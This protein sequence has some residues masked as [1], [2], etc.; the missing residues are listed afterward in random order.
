MYVL[1]KTGR[2]PK[3]CTPSKARHLQTFQEWH[4]VLLWR[5][6]VQWW[7]AWFKSFE[8]I[9]SIR[10]CSFIGRFSRRF[11]RGFTRRWISVIQWIRWWWIKVGQPSDDSGCS[12]LLHQPLLC[13]AAVSYCV[14]LLLITISTIILLISKITSFSQSCRLIYFHS[15]KTGG[16][17]LRLFAPVT[18]VHLLIDT[19]KR[20]T[21]GCLLMFQCLVRILETTLNVSCD[22]FSLILLKLV[23]TNCIYL[24]KYL[25]I[26]SSTSLKTGFIDVSAFNSFVSNFKCRLWLIYFNFIE[27]GGKKLRLFVPVRAWHLLISTFKKRMFSCLL[28]FNCLI[29]LFE[30]TLNVSCD[31]F[32]LIPCKLVEIVFIWWSSCAS[33]DPKL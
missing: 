16:N 33:V 7:A 30:T 11:T 6:Y 14:Q 4:H 19:V 13:P 8:R 15:I 21:F 1:R 29:R 26:C 32:T 9:W 5:E 24:L 18:T 17:S 3:L 25:R 12:H 28:M 10:F 20:T 23:V 22:W 31:W 27:T 2:A